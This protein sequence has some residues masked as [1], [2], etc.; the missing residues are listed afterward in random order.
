[1]KRFTL[2]TLSMIALL[3]SYN[4]L[5]H[6][7]EFLDT[8]KTPHGGQLRMAGHY[9]LELVVTE[10]SLTV[11]VTDHAGAA[12]PTKNGTGNAIVL[13]NKTKTTVELEPVD[14]NVLQGEGKFVLDPNMKVV[15][16][17]TLPEDK[18]P[19]QARFEPLIKQQK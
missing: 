9:H 12:I 8:Q 14:D 7:D 11:Y 1:M 13:A 19:Q 3:F 15:V 4:S 10:K 16:S 17:V 5:A 2:T 18:E 6:T